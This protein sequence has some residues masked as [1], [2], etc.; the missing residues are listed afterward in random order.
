MPICYGH[1]HTPDEK[2]G[3][4]GTERLGHFYTEIREI[5]KNNKDGTSRQTVITDMLTDTLILDEVKHPKYKIKVSTA[6]GEQ[7]GYLMKSV[8][9]GITARFSKGYPYA[10]FADEILSWRSGGGYSNFGVSALIIRV[11]PR[12]PDDEICDYVH[13]NFHREGLAAER[14]YLKAFGLISKCVPPDVITPS[15]PAAPPVS[16]K[17]PP[18][19][20]AAMANHGV[21]KSGCAWFIIC[22]A[23]I[24]AVSALNFS[25]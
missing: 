7:I 14:R 12:V 11:A 20:P 8:G 5:T 4:F 21:K 18:L 23:L 3:N 25:G 2:K 15:A 24:T 10:A 22:L 13:E 6:Y 9:N 19:P 1:G 16:H 17:E